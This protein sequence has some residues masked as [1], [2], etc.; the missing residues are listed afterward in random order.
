MSSLASYD[1]GKLALTWCLVNRP[2]VVVH[3]KN[4]PP[5]LFACVYLIRTPRA[6]CCRTLSRQMRRRPRGC[7]TPERN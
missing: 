3:C 1:A 2:K 6:R 7:R 4:A 5:V